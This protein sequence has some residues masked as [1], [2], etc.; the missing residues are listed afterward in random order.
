MTD[1][2]DA[3]RLTLYDTSPPKSDAI[4]YIKKLQE[5]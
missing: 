3:N 5:L 1:A 4:I 2:E